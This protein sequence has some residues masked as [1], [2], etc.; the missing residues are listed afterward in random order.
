[1]AYDCGMRA[2]SIFLCVVALACGG[3]DDPAVT[4]ERGGTTYQVGESFSDG[5]N[6]CVC[7]GDGTVGCTDAV[8]VDAGMPTDGGTDASVPPADSG[9]TDGGNLDCAT[10]SESNLTGVEVQ[11]LDQDCVFTVAEAAAGIDIEYDV[12]VSEEPANVTTRA[13]DAGRCGSIGDSGLIVFEDLGGGDERFCLCDTGLCAGGDMATSPVL[14]FH[15]GTFQWMGRNWG[16]P[17]DTGIPMGAPFPPGSYTLTVSAVGDVAG[18]AY[19]VEGTFTVHL[20]P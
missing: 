10:T 2:F 12:V 14:G 13:Q 15:R 16:G 3:D 18:A 8:C 9:P 6:S 17:S 20:I 7:S 4:C 11:F 1:M 19:R 5:C